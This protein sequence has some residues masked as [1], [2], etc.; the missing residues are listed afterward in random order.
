MFQNELAQIS[1][2]WPLL[3]WSLG[4]SSTFFFIVPHWFTRMRM[5]NG[6]DFLRLFTFSV[7]LLF[8]AVKK[9]EKKKFRHAACVVVLGGADLR[10]RLPLALLPAQLASFRQKRAKSRGAGEAKKAAKRTGPA[11]AQDDGAAQDS[12]I[13]PP[14][15]HNELHGNSIHE[16]LWTVNRLHLQYLLNDSNWW[17]YKSRILATSFF[18]TFYLFLFL[19]YFLSGRSKASLLYCIE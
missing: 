5:I 7:P 13:V 17:R 8:W 4:I 1:H 14:P 6:T 16:V 18:V 15:N 11:V 10:V 9:K 12:H 19:F 2:E 3:S